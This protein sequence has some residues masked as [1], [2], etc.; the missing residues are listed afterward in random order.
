MSPRREVW[1][2]LGGLALLACRP[3]FEDDSWHV[4]SARVLAVKSE[5]A[6]ARPGAHHTFTA[7]LSVREAPSAVPVWSFCSAPKPLTEN[8]AVSAACLGSSALVPLGAGLSLEADTPRAGCSSFGPDSPPGGFRPR[9]PDI[10]G[11]YYQ[12]LR[13]DLAGAQPAFHL[14]RIACELADAAA[15]TA[16]QFGLSYVPNQNPSLDPIT[17]TVSGQPVALTEIPSAARVELTLSWAESEAETFT[18]YDRAQQALTRKREAMRVSWYV[19]AGSLDTDSTGR[20]END[21]E[22]RVANHWIAPKTPGKYGLWVV[23]RDSRG[24]VDF[25]A[26]VLEVRP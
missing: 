25:S 23:L 20:A 1:L 9:D 26:Y 3:E 11:G 5:P 17:A 6:E 13:L 12:P 16:T 7:F 2:L 14:Q 22:L 15:G 8:N 4:D 19:D 21:L 10:T 24:G 18:Y